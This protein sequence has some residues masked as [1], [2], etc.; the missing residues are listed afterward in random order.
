MFILLFNILMAKN[1]EEQFSKNP[2][3][4]KYNIYFLQNIVINFIALY[5]HNV[6]YISLDFGKE[7][8]EVLNSNRSMFVI[9]DNYLNQEIIIYTDE[10]F[11][12]FQIIF[13]IRINGIHL[14]L[15]NEYEILKNNIDKLKQFFNYEM[16]GIINKIFD[17]KKLISFEPEKLNSMILELIKLNPKITIKNLALEIGVERRIVE[18]QI[19]KLK[20]S[21]VLQRMGT[22]NSGYWQIIEDN[23]KI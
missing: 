13:N 5:K 16:D 23:N 14:E 15:D 19:V 21:G 8:K 17:A 11:K 9:F 1:F 2:N 18:K 12:Y 22:A 6:N 3:I 20:R 4:Y 7:L 10:L